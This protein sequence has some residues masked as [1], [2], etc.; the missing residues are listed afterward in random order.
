MSGRVTFEHLAETISAAFAD[1]KRPDPDNVLSEFGKKEYPGGRSHLEGLDWRN[2]ID[3]YDKESKTIR[4]T[5]VLD[6]SDEAYIYYLPGYMMVTAKYYYEYNHGDTVIGT[7]LL[8]DMGTEKAYL[9]KANM[10][11]FEMLSPSQKHAVRSFLEY[12][13]QEYRQEMKWSHPN[14]PWMA[15]A[16]YWKRF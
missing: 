4:L 8:Y 10:R 7:L 2:V 14:S 5:N 16:Q 9:N 12:M 15:L 6:L 3:E 11:R 1:V 13:I